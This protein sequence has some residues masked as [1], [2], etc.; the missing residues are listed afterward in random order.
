MGPLKAVDCYEPEWTYGGL[1]EPIISPDPFVTLFRT[2]MDKTMSTLF[3]KSDDNTAHFKLRN[4]VIQSIHDKFNSLSFEQ[5]AIRVLSAFSSSCS[6]QKSNAVAILTL[7]D[8]EAIGSLPSFLQNS[9]FSSKGEPNLFVRE[10]NL[11]EFPSSLQDTIEFAKR[12]GGTTWKDDLCLVPSLASIH[13]YK[14]CS[15]NSVTFN[16]HDTQYSSM[17]NEFFLNS[18]K[19]N[20]F[21]IVI[22]FYGYAHLITFYGF[23][24]IKIKGVSYPMCYCSE[25]P[26]KYLY[27]EPSQYIMEV[28]KPCPLKL[29]RTVVSMDRVRQAIFLDKVVDDCI[30]VI[31][32]KTF[33]AQY[34]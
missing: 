12:I 15:Y 14:T 32:D 8:I 10:T 33:S 29:V 21:G 26:V 1:K 30:L 3:D 28:I 18:N 9:F 11:N 16:S 25:I 7:W 27:D 2:H 23:F 31:N 13:L 20:N 17:T 24:S 4:E 6:Y 5:F 34:L 19:D 22:D